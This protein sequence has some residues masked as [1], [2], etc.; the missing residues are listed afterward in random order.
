[1]TE[2]KGTLEDKANKPE[3]KNGDI[4][5]LLCRDGGQESYICRGTVTDKVEKRY[6]DMYL[7]DMI[8]GKIR[9]D[10][11]FDPVAGYRLPKTPCDEKIDR[12]V[13]GELKLARTFNVGVGDSSVDAEHLRHATLKEHLQLWRCNFELTLFR[14]SNGGYIDY[15]GYYTPGTHRQEFLRETQEEVQERY[16][17]LEKACYDMDCEI[18]DTLSSQDKIQN[19]KDL[20]ME[21]IKRAAILRWRVDL[22]GKLLLLLPCYINRQYDKRFEAMERK[23]DHDISQICG[24][25]NLVASGLMARIHQVE[26]WTT[27]GQ[28]RAEVH[29][30]NMIR[31]RGP[32]KVY[33]YGHGF[34]EHPL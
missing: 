21:K 18:E 1:M 15:K 24:Y 20:P 27:E 13:D 25:I 31:E 2:N 3:F 33:D 7:Y 17:K 19:N 32:G 30:L 28:I 29:R 8:T 4:I 34:V 9:L 10:S 26:G 22:D 14:M 12:I 23:I 16:L 11:I 6:R 5:V